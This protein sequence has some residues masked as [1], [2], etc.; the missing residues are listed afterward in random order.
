MER[1]GSVTPGGFEELL[2]PVLTVELSASEFV[3]SGDADIGWLGF[4]GGTGNGAL[5]IRETGERFC[6]GDVLALALGES[7][8]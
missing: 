1:S 2:S 7:G 4:E 5:A 6:A 3:I 8:L